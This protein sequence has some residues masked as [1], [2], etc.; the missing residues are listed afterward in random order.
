MGWLESY[1]GTVF[2]WET[3]TTD[4]FTVAYYFDRFSDA[5]L[6]AMDS[7]GLGM[8]YIRQQGRTCA[9]VDCYVRYLSELRAGDGLHIESAPIAV[10]EK[11]VKLGHKVFNSETGELACTLEQYTVHFDMQARKAVPLS[12]EQV[13]RVQGRLVAWDGEPRQERPDPAGDDGFVD[14]ARDTVKPWE[15]DLLGHMGF[16]FYVH[17]FSNAGLQL[18]LKLGLTPRFMRE[19]KRGFS[20]FEFQLRFRRELKAGD[21]VRIR[22]AL[23][24]LGNSSVCVLHR[25]YNVETGELSAQ[26]SQ[27]GVLLDMAA[28]RPTRIPAEIRASAEAL[29]VTG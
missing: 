20:T 1:R 23:T 19:Q 7:L 21:H 17:R 11:G 6:I 26:L 18:L 12:P 16:Q 14:T 22:S 3:D 29:M 25:L 10:D 8:S 27:Y 28:R 15:I 2:A 4:H 9:S 5:T 13:E 24:H